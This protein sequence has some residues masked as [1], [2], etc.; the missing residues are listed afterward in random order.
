MRIEDVSSGASVD[1]LLQ[2][3]REATPQAIDGYLIYPR[4][5]A[6]G[7]TMLHRALPIGTEDFLSFDVRPTISEI[8]YQI[9]IRQGVSGLRLVANTLEMI[10][11]GG[12]PRLRV[13]PPYL[14][15]ASGARTNAMLAVYGCAVDTNPAAP[16]GRPVT[17]PGST[18]CT[19]RVRCD[20]QPLP[21]PPFLAPPST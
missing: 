6:S 8:V 9:T 5:H 11:A 10:D 14:V 20:H 4:A 12:A 15:D 18:T 7:A 17:P 3:A 1:V 21:Y 19:V 13:S 16:W 2:D